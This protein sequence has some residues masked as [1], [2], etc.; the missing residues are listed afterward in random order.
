MCEDLKL[1]STS[2]HWIKYMTTELWNVVIEIIQTEDRGGKINKNENL[3]D[4][5]IG[6]TSTTC[7]TGLSKTDRVTLEQEK[8]MSY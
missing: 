2:A 6:S 5:W 3:C 1:M 8:K 4:N 7:K